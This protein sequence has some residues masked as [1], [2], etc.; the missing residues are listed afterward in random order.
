[1]KKYYKI[2]FIEIISNTSKYSSIIYD[3]RHNDLSNKDTISNESSK[4]KEIEIDTSISNISMIKV[5]ETICYKEDILNKKGA[6][7]R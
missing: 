6:T 4:A 1:M 7:K 5:V 2:D 3:Q